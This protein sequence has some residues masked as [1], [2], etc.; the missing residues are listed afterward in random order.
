MRFRTLIPIAVV[1][2]AA[3]SLLAAGYGDGSSPTAATTTPN[4]LVAYSECMRSHGVP[5]FPDPM[6]REGIPKDKVVAA[7]VSSPQSRVAQRDCLRLM[8]KSGLGPTESTPK[9]AARL[10]DALSFAK[11]MRAHGF[12]S[13]PDPTNQGQLTPQM[14]SA[15]ASTC[16]SQDC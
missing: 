15:A 8:P 2:V 11:C 6:S 12:Q 16:I 7:L 10:A 13:F 4:G 1:A 14:A 9:T 5:N 3:L